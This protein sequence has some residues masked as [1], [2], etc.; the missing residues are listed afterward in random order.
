MLLFRLAPHCSRYVAIDF[1]EAAVSHVAAEARARGLTQVRTER[2]GADELD[3]LQGEAPFDV[4]VINSVV[5]Y[6]PNA[7]YLERFLVE[8]YGRLAPGGSLFIGDVRSLQHLDAF[9]RSVELARAPDE[10]TIAELEARVA[11]R[12][13][14]EVELVVAPGFF[15]AMAARLGDAAGVRVE[16]KAGRAHNEL[17]RFRY[18]VVI[19]KGSGLEPAPVQSIQ[20][21]TAPASCSTADL[22]GLLRKSPGGL[23]VEGVPNERVAALIAAGDL[24]ASFGQGR[25]GELRTALASA[26]RT[27]GGAVDPEDVRQATPEYDV[28]M[29]FAREHADRMDIVFRTRPATLALEV[30]HGGPLATFVNHPARPASRAG[31]WSAVLN[32]YLKERL[33]EAMIPTAIVALD[34]FPLTANGKVDRARLPAPAPRPAP[35]AAAAM[36][37][38]PT[39]DVQRAIAAV[40]EGLLPGRE[41]GLDDNFFELGANSLMMVQASV[42]LREALGRSVPLIKLFQFPSVRALAAAITS[43]PAD[44]AETTQGR[45][46]AQARQDAMQKRR[47]VRSGGRGTRWP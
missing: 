29:T 32:A 10:M 27:G 35:A 13:A 12:A 24:C 5:Q 20:T 16:V 14:D 40:F 7:E 43:Q 8:A 37:G 36:T 22:L 41:I 34:S 18:D 30:E 46:R 15:H 2:L 47:D 21:V 19:R 42:R 26:A 9:H 39:E 4:V 28:Q 45:E 23:R 25:V 33:P 1:S 44:A 38:E 3:A 31:S 11:R 17:T 6:F